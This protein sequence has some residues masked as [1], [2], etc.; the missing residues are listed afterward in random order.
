MK[1]MDEKERIAEL[2][3]LL[4]A[5][6]RAYYV[7]NSPTISDKEFDDLMHELE[8]LEKA[9]LEM[10]DPDSPTQRVGSDLN[11]DFETVAHVRPMISLSN[12]YN[13][14]EVRDFYRRVE[15]GLQ[16]QPFQICCEL[17]YDG[18]SI[19]LHYEDG[20][21]VRALTRG[22]GTKGDDVTVNVR[23]IRSIPLRVSNE[24]SFEIR[25]EVLLPW[26]SFERLN[27]EREERGE[28]LFANPRNAASGTLKSKDPRVCAARGL[29]AYL[30]YLLGEDIPGDSHYDNMMAAKAWGFKVSSDM[31]LCNTLD[32]VMEYIHHWDEARRMLPVATDGVVLKVNSL[33]QQKTLGMTAKSP[34]WAIAYKFRAEQASTKLR[35]VTYQVGRTGVVTPVANM[36][37]VLLAGTV[38]KRATLH[39]E[40]FMQQLDLHEG[41]PVLIEKGGEIIPKV[42][43][44]D[45]D[46]LCGERGPRI[47]FVERCPEC[48]TPLRKDTETDGSEKGASWRCPNEEGCRPQILGRIEHFVSRRAMAIDSIGPETIASLYDRG[49]IKD[50]ADLY[51]L[52]MDILCPP[53][54]DF[55]GLPLQ[56]SSS[57]KTTHKL[58]QNIL[59]GIDAS[60]RVPFERVLFAIGIRYVGE[61]AAKALAGYFKSMEAL[62]A[63]T[64]EQLLEV[65]GIGIIIA[66]S[67]VR[68]FREEKNI[69][70]VQRLEQAGLR[71]TLSEE[72][73][74]R[75]STRLEGQTIVISGVF[76][77]HSRDEYK[78]LIE[79]H[80][81]KNAGS[82]SGRTT[83]VLAGDDMGPAKR[84]KAQKL[85][86][87]LV[88]E[89]EFL[90]MIKE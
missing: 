42:V 37:P 85:G 16:G 60:R 22:D 84:E 63:A 58:E 52:T 41:D 43:Q 77:Q 34:R 79:Q 15:N 19:A 69:A 48:G 81:G 67:V 21:L 82:I 70:F 35:K 62:K 32:E 44:V 64:M 7:D 65:N 55:F 68:F 6:N 57:A 46:A 66:E 14:T 89:D 36:D 29:D 39:N 13:E 53:A 86:V 9:H 25:G 54:T 12:T 3:V 76:H 47:R 72:Q 1:V 73:L 24:K 61:I 17:K 38:V 10:Y 2:R 75:H 18:L 56:E 90:E 40:A 49:L 78:T 59:D 33:A 23:T 87:R 88:G 31:K 80:G 26:S 71:M 5:H 30:Y 83:M 51:D 11:G 4:D 50:A 8:R 27:A 74:T 20:R 45:T 28:E